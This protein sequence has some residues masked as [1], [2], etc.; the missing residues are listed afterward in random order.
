MPGRSNARPRRRCGRRST[1]LLWASAAITVAA[2]TV[3]LTDSFWVAVPVFLVIT[4]SIGVITPVRQA[5]V[6]QV[7]P[8]EHRATVISFDA[9]V[10]SVG[11]V[12]GQLTL[13]GVAESRSLSAGYVV[14]GLFTVAALP[15]LFM[16]RRFGGPADAIVGDAAVEGTCA[17]AGLPANTQVESQPV[18]VVVAEA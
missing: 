13:G 9:M 10:G 18:P 7:I 5:Y 16:M 12:G 2:V 6:H 4:F 1:L 3:G 15:F 11:G 14:G 17:A 8:S